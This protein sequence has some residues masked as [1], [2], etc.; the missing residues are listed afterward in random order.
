[1]EEPSF[2]TAFEASKAFEASSLAA[3]SS[4]LGCTKA[5]ALLGNLPFAMDRHVVVGTF[6]VEDI[7]PLGIEHSLQAVEQLAFLAKRSLLAHQ[8][9][10][11]QI[12]PCL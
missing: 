11:F 12:V 7:L 4:C 9:S 10:P 5:F 2:H 3:A 1:M 6:A 8:I